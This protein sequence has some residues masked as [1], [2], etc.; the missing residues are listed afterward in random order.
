MQLWHPFSQKSRQSV[1]QGKHQQILPG[2]QSIQRGYAYKMT[3][4]AHC[5]HKTKKAAEA[6]FLWNHC[7]SSRR[8]CFCRGC[9]R[10]RLFAAITLL[11]LL[12]TA[13]HVNDFLLAGVERV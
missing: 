11:E 7:V 2:E 12:N 3:R 9:R 6:A 5:T 4:I 13:C 8:G 10:C 1:G